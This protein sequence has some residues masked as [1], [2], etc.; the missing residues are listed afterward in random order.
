M[1]EA[2]LYKKNSDGSV[3]CLTCA[4]KCRIANGKRGIC[5]VRENRDS[6]LYTLVYGNPV[7][8]HI[9]PIEKKPLF[10][11]LPGSSAFSIATV[12]CNMHCL[13]C[14]NADISQAGPEEG[15]GFP[16]VS[17][18]DIVKAAFQRECGSIAYTYTEP[19]IFF[20]YAY[21][22]SLLADKQGIKNIFITNGFWS[23]EALKEIAPFM[24]GANVDLKFFKDEMYKK[25]CGAK[26]GPVLDTI[27]RMKE[28]GVWVELTTLVIPGLNDSSEELKQIAEFIVSVDK[29]IPWH[30]SRF[31]PTYKMADIPP[32]SADTL[33]NAR[34]IGFEAGLR[35]VYTGNIPGD[36]GENTFCPSCGRELI[37]R[38][39][40]STGNINIKDGKCRWCGE[41]IE[42]VWQS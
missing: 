32:T 22:I 10:H 2:K 21:D 23:K 26:L 13:N 42:G 30:I 19:A 40:F 12:G 25:I 38:Y 14:Q 5:R 3:T 41:D 37:S 29:S 18:E 34:E 36:T 8:T 6:R 20:D 17:P 15:S 24:H 35:F 7:A 28:L 33:K 9:D 1:K 16:A 4:H 31:Y 27:I 11:F 39:G